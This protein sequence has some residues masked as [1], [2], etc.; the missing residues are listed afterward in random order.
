VAA[1]TLGRRIRNGNPGIKKA[2][3]LDQERRLQPRRTNARH[4]VRRRHDPLLVGRA[5]ECL[6]TLLP[7]AEGG[8]GGRVSRRALQ[9]I[10]QPG[11]T[12]NGC[13]NVGRRI[14]VG[15]ATERSQALGQFRYS[16]RPY[17]RTGP[18]LRRFREFGMADDMCGQSHPLPAVAYGFGLN[19][20]DPF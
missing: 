7:L 1:A 3:E 12:R 19:E 5:G 20:R 17:A 16:G 8:W 4:R 10:G 6:A 11:P 15:W 9:A 2:H 14:L 13:R 18:G